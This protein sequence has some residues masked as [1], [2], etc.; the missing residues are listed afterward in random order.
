[1]VNSNFGKQFALRCLN[2]PVTGH[3]FEDTL[4]MAKATK[5]GLTPE[6]A[7]IEFRVT[8]GKLGYVCKKI[9]VNNVL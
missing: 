7:I 2:V 9:L 3:S 4:L 1:M 6:A 8:A 5:L